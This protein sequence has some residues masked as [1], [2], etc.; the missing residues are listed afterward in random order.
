MRS[1]E[2]PALRWVTTSADVIQRRKAKDRNA[3]GEREA[4]AIHGGGIGQETQGKENQDQDV[5]PA[6]ARIRPVGR[7]SVWSQPSQEI[8]LKS[9]LPI[10]DQ[11][12]ILSAGIKSEFW[13]LMVTHWRPQLE[14]MIHRVIDH[15]TDNPTD[16]DR[17]AERA[18]MLEELLQWPE[19]QLEIIRRNLSIKPNSESNR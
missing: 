4:T 12:L 3:I 8:H 9:Q 18:A 15:R 1:S 13:Q 7:R 10:E 6:A 17:E 19:R 2:S 14:K 16:R 11:E 5:G